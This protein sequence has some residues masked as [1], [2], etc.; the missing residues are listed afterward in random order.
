MLAHDNRSIGGTIMNVAVT[1]IAI[2]GGA[3]GPTAIYIASSINWVWFAA[4]VV[5]V[6]AAIL[7]I[8]IKKRKK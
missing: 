6:V 1:D 3:D 4:V 2:I 7:F 5:L 8:V